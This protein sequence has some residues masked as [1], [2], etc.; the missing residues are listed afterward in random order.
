MRSPIFNREVP[1]YNGM[2]IAMHRALAHRPFRMANAA[3][4]ALIVA[5]ALLLYAAAYPLLLAAWAWALEQGVQALGLAVK[6]RHWPV[7]WSTDSQWGI[8]RLVLA[9]PMPAVSRM[10]LLVLAMVCIAGWVLLKRLRDAWTPVAYALRVLMALGLASCVYFWCW[11][12]HFPYRL[13][14]HTRDIYAFNVGLQWL[15]P[16]VLGLTLFPIVSGPV[17]RIL[18]CLTVQ[19]YF[20]LTLPIKVLAHAWLALHLGAVALPLLFLAFGPVLD[21]M[22]MVALYAWIATWFTAPDADQDP[23]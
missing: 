8:D 13:A 15:V 21:V 9:G 10:A 3:A 12:E 4:G 7:A 19:G 5:A 1:G 11:P 23:A 18:A 16:L 17:H 2:P 6:V 20:V 14:D 22:L